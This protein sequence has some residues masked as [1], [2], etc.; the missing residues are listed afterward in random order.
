FAARAVHWMHSPQSIPPHDTRTITPSRNAPTIPPSR[1]L[2][3]PASARAPVVATLATRCPPAPPERWRQLPLACRQT[4]PTAPGQ[5]GP[6][7]NGIVIAPVGGVGGKQISLLC[8][9]AAAAA[10]HVSRP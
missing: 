1:R 9:R 5:D 4:A 7:H 6:S 8:R 10:R 3:S 2:V